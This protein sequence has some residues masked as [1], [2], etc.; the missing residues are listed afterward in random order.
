MS[1]MPDDASSG[2]TS[3]DDASTGPSDEMSFF[4]SVMQRRDDADDASDSSS[5]NR[6]R[7]LKRILFDLA[8]LVMHADG[9]AHQSEKEI[10]QTLAERMEA[11]GSVDV[12]ARAEAL[13][14]VLD[15]GMPA[16]RSR[17]QTFADEFTDLAGDE[18][19]QLAESFLALLQELI[20]A[21]ANVSPEEYE[22]F[23]VLATRWDADQT[24]T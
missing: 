17:I 2:D 18:A 20:R 22:F 21:D 14:P 5:E 16:V 23:N 15:E 1:T 9:A 19:S 3:F 7:K 8:Y 12:D 4:D 24:L 6:A 13:A 11:E 10:V